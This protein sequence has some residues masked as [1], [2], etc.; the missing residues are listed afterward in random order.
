MPGIFQGWRS[1]F[2]FLCCV[3]LT[4]CNDPINMYQPVDVASAGWSSRLDFEIT[5]AG[6]YQLALL[7]TEGY[8][9]HN[10]DAVEKRMEELYEYYKGKEETIPLIVCLLKDGQLIAKKRVG[11]GK[12]HDSWRIV[13]NERAVNIYSRDGKPVALKAGHYS[14]IIITLREAPEFNGLKTFVSLKKIREIG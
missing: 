9:W 12:E 10:H 13:Y 14:A 1:I 2:I 4:A 6:R 7:L 11:V 3:G 5:S 8:T